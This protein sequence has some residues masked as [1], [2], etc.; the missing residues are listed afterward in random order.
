MNYRRRSDLEFFRLADEQSSGNRMR[1]VVRDPLNRQCF[2]LGEEEYFL[3][4]KL[5]GEQKF[6]NIKQQYE[7]EFAPRELTSTE[8]QNLI[9]DWAVKGLLNCEPLMLQKIKA[10]SGQQVNRKPRSE[11]RQRFANPIV[12]R[13]RGWDP[14]R[15]LERLDS[16]TGFFFSRSFIIAS[17]LLIL[18]AISIAVTRFG[19]IV[20]DASQ[21]PLLFRP[22]HWLIIILL[23]GLTKVLHEFGHALTCHRY[24]GRCHEMGIMFLAFMPC[25]YCNVTDAWTFPRRYQRVAV[26]AAGILVDL[27]IAAA[28]LILWS[29]TQPGFFHSACL[30]LAIFGSVNS[31]LLNGNPLMRYDGYYIVSDFLGIPNMRTESQKQARQRFWYF[32]FGE[33]SINRPS[34]SLSMVTYGI[35]SGI[36]LWLVVLLILVGIHFMLKPLHLE[37]FA[38]ILGVLIVPAQLQATGKQLYREGKSE[39]QQRGNRKT[40]TIAAGTIV[41]VMLLMLLFIPLP[42]RVPAVGFLRPC[43]N[44]AIVTTNSGNITAASVPGSKVGVG[45]IVLQLEDVYLDQQMLELQNRIKKLNVKIKALQIKRTLIE[46]SSE[47]LL[48]L[49]QIRESLQNQWTQLTQQ[50]KSLTL[51]AKQSGTLIPDPQL[52]GI[53][54][55]KNRQNNRH[56]EIPGVSL[57]EENCLGAF[58]PAGT[59]IGTIAQ[60]D[61]YEVLIAVEEHWIRHVQAGANVIVYPSDRAMNPLT[62]KLKGISRSMHS[63]SSELPQLLPEQHLLHHYLNQQPGN[64]RKKHL[65]AVIGIDKQNSRLLSYYQ[66]C[67]VRLQT[68]DA[69]LWYRITD[70]LSRTFKQF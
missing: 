12:I 38:L 11:F 34:F 36:Y 61:S 57:L 59:R 37:V 47:T 25:L 24:G 29:I 14:Q 30:L 45:T 20:S 56:Q 1:W 35:A 44:Q 52:T 15:F 40:R 70:Y 53:R 67:N 2:H 39:Y 28:C 10:A 7:L 58:I 54:L 65:F 55:T 18:L 26:S 5:T 66:L 3:L 46:N 64:S 62:G 41:T 17:L 23:I 48:V 42:R 60:P 21:L 63:D 13:F 19:D 43:S 33:R 51:T 69:S 49:K 27:W 32:L 9:A 22:Q 8:F 31:I 50:K 6:S 4:N 68:A 16:V